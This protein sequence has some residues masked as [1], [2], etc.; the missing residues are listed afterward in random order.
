MIYFVCVL[1][2]ILLADDIFFSWDDF[3]VLHWCV[4]LMTIPTL[5]SLIS[6]W[7]WSLATSHTHTCS[8]PPSLSHCTWNY[9]RMRTIWTH[10]PQITTDC[11]LR[12]AH[13]WRTICDVRPES[14]SLRMLNCRI[15][16]VA[17]VSCRHAGTHFEGNLLQQNRIILAFFELTV[18]AKCIEF[19]KTR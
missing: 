2:V 12:A 6:M 5:N 13:R 1:Y 3:H 16:L 9:E 19:S 14:E 17:S 10:W 18:P 4:C 15:L 8:L 11:D 7:C